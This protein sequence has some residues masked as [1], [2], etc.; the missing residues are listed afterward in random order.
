MAPTHS[1]SDSE[2]N[3]VLKAL[4]VLAPSAAPCALAVGDA[5][6]IV[7]CALAVGDA[8]SNWAG[9]VIGANEQQLQTCLA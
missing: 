2:L 3:G 5:A 6:A 7:S 1:L 4:G 9:R 8:A